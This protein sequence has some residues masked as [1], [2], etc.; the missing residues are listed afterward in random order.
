MVKTIFEEMGGTYVR[1]GDYLIPCLT[2][3]AEKEQSLG[4]FGQRHLRYLKEYHRLTYTN[5]LTSGKLNTYLADIDR[6]AQ[7]RFETLTELM[8]QAQGVTEQLK[9]EN[10]IDWVGRMNNIRHRAMEIVNHEV[11]YA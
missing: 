5:L 1:Q 2:L 10:Q 3:P 9:A 6:Q 8:K 7:E 4:L 11:I